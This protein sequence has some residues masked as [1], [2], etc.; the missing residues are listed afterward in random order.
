MIVLAGGE[1]ASRGSLA[2]SSMLSSS[3]VYFVF[4]FYFLI[5]DFFSSVFSSV[6]LDSVCE[7]LKNACTCAE[8]TGRLRVTLLAIKKQWQACN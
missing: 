5:F 3:F 2:F 8:E 6:C 7:V 1:K 4:I